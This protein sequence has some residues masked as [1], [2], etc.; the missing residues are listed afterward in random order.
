MSSEYRVQLDAFE[1]P[2]D[3]LLYLIRRAE[4][5][6][7]DVP[8]AE[9]TDQYLSYLS[10]IDRI[11]IDTAGEFLVM[12]ATLMEIKSRMLMPPE[13]RPGAR[14]PHAGREGEGQATDPRADLIR[15][16]LEY[17]RYRDAADRLDEHRRVWEQRFPA[18]AAGD[19]RAKLAEATA[20][21][22]DPGVDTED[23]SIFDLVE[24][25]AKVVETV[26]FDRLGEHTVVVDD[27]P[28]E[29][30]AEDILE[31]LRST[32]GASGSAAEL[33]FRDIFE[34]RSRSELVGLFLAILEL[35]KQQRIAVAQ[36]EGGSAADIT[37]QL[38]DSGSDE[39]VQAAE[40]AAPTNADT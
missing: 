25:F 3:L 21:M 12:A 30:H 10:Q 23:L 11:D 31:R 38:R 33:P 40:T 36:S 8:I 19:D 26:N 18:T 14:G 5:D 16:L 28:I 17:K 35:V 32:P 13:E 29:L 39:G 27:T 1:G 15:Q 37:L 9:L 24:A 20:G 22:D 2:L 34:G 4:V 6:V 7:T